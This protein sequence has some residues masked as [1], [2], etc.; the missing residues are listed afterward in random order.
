MKKF[1]KDFVIEGSTS[2]KVTHH[3]YHRFYPWFLEHIR[4]KSV[5]VLEIGIDKTESLKLW[6]GYFENLNLH[7]IDIDKKSFGDNS[8]TLHQVDQSNTQQLRFFIENIGIQFDLILDD[9]SH[10][11]NHQ[12]LTL[13]TLWEILKPGGVY[14]IED[15]ETSYWGK[16]SIYGYDFNANRSSIIIPFKELVDVLNT[17]FS[18]KKSR[19]KFLKCIADEIEMVTFGQN[20]IILIKKDSEDFSAFYGRKYR[21]ENRIDYRS[22]KNFPKRLM[23]RIRRDLF[24][25]K[26]E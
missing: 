1:Q 2:D 12:M 24:R 8:V 26:A 10:V 25:I 23:R 5:N 15:I 18:K 3:G 20:C 4:K 17:E 19:N 21:L 11:P 6:G 9:G 13:T 7:G 14:I 16:S 22:V